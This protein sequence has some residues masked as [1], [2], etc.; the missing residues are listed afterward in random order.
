MVGPWRMRNVGTYRTSFS[1]QNG[2]KRS[3][4]GSK[5]AK[6]SSA[7]DSHL[8][9]TPETLGTRGRSNTL[10]SH[11]DWSVLICLPPISEP[12]K[13]VRGDAPNVAQGCYGWHLLDVSAFYEFLEG[14]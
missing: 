4:K 1:E 11:Y 9:W 12:P 7:T 14:V 5:G 13:P 6:G 10:S 3:K 2:A 8:A